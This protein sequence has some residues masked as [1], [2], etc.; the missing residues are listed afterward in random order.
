VKCNHVRFRK[1]GPKYLDDLHFLFDKVHV[2]GAT[3]FCPGDISSGESSSDD[4]L[5]VAQK[6]D[7]S[8]AIKLKALK[9]PKATG[10]KRKQTCGAAEDKEERSP[11][12]RMYKNTCLKIDSVAD[13]IGS[14]VEASSVQPSSNVPSLPD[15][16]KLVKECGVQEKTAM[17][18]T[19]AL[20]I[21]KPE[22]RHILFLLETK[23]GRYDFIEREHEKEMKKAA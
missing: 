2:T 19:A 4:V 5:E 12:F 6:E 13:K 18:H 21:M 22:F 20:L 3:A 16:M 14:S 23:E 17:M 7:D 15:A 10:K 1:R 9:K 8:S 11:F